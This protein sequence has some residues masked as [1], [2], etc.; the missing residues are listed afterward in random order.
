M[1]PGIHRGDLIILHKP[2]TR[3][4]VTGDIVVYEIP[5]F[6][7]P[8][9]HRVLEARTGSNTKR[10]GAQLLLTKGDNNSEDDRVLYNGPDYIDDTQVVGVVKGCAAACRMP[11]HD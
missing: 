1:E 3:E 10:K 7:V 5:N 6:G 8:I 9:V 4:Y 11:K 2:R